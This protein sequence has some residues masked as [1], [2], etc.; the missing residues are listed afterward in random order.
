M[1]DKTWRNRIVGYADIPPEQL[2][3]NEHNFRIHPKAQ[4]LALSGLI[5]E[6][7][8]LDPVVV[9]QGTD[10]VI[11]GHLRVELA[12]RDGV[13]TIPIQYV[14]LTDDEANIALA[15]FDPISVLAKTDAEKLG[16]LLGTVSPRDAALSKLLTDL[17]HHSGVEGYGEPGDI[18]TLKADTPLYEPTAETPPAVAALCATTRHDALCAAIEAAPLPDDLRAFLTTAATRHIVFDYAKIAEYYAHAEPEVQRLMEDSAL[19]II[20]IN[21]AIELGYAKLRDEMLDA[22][23]DARTNA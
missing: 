23:E 14:D 17:A 19:V 3:A 6:I 16:A 4:K 12:L 9:Q 15:S 18:Y 8:Y 5:N 21:R 22:L 20:D 13:E 7:G 1:T 2:L 10:R 11:D